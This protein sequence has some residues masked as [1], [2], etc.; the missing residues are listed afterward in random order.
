M[1]GR[2]V[3]L[4]DSAT[5]YEALDG[6]WANIDKAWR[7]KKGEGTWTVKWK[8]AGYGDTVGIPEDHV[9]VKGGVGD[10]GGGLVQ[11]DTKQIMVGYEKQVGRSKEAL[12]GYGWGKVVGL[13]VIKQQLQG[14]AQYYTDPTRVGMKEAQRRFLFYGYGQC[15]CL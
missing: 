14:F 9:R 4:S 7:K 11:E 5:E 2:E 15:W 12:K 1:S 13:D 8:K 3:L 10:G 6:V